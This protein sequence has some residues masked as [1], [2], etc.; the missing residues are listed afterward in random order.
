MKRLVK[1]CAARGKFFVREERE[2]ERETWVPSQNIH[3]ISLPAT[4]KHPITF[5]EPN[6]TKKERKKF[7]KKMKMEISDEAKGQDPTQSVQS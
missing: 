2:R 3:E 1:G 6:S 5:V 7:L 4:V